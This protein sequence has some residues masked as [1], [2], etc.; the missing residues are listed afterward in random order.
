MV[1][2]HRARSFARG[3]RSGGSVSSAPRP[4][5]PHW[6]DR[7]H[8]LAPIG[9]QREGLHDLAARPGAD[10]VAPPP[11]DRLA[12][13]TPRRPSAHPHRLPARAR[14]RESHGRLSRG[15]GGGGRRTREAARDAAPLEADPARARGARVRHDAVRDPAD[16][17]RLSPAAQYR[18]ADGLHRAARG[19]L[20]VQRG[21]GGPLPAELQS[22]PVREA[23]AHR[24]PGA[25]HRADRD[26]VGI[27]P[28][29]VASRYRRRQRTPPARA[30]GHLPRA[31]PVRRMG[32]LAARPNDVLVFRPADAD[33]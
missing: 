20:P 21:D 16:S 7:V 15:T 4:R 28:L 14:I 23:A 33:R 30:R 3:S 22:R 17:I 13:R 8:R 12:R 26:V 10:L 29:A 27:L 25:D 19:V 5:D 11:L 2:R 9:R 18:R 24:P 1:P 32:S 31:R 6:R